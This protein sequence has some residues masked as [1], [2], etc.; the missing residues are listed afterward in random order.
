MTEEN[1][2]SDDY[3]QL[4]QFLKLNGLTQSG[5]EAKFL[6]QDGQVKVNGV[7][8]TRRKK[9]LRDGDKIEAFGKVLVVRRSNEEA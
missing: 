5:G 3:I 9:K 8:E 2:D 7:V 6:I 1:D 4:D